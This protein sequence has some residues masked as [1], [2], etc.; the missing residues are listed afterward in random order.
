MESINTGFILPTQNKTYFIKYVRHE[1]E[2]KDLNLSRNIGASETISSSNV[3]M[4]DH[5]EPKNRK[6]KSLRYICIIGDSM[7]KHITR[8]G[9]SNND[10]E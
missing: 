8:P 9:I 1:K 3:K 7:V 5:Q 6:K 10:Q 2:N 4:K